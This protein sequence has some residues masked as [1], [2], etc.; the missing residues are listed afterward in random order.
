MNENILNTNEIWK[1]T[2]FWTNEI[3]KSGVHEKL[4]FFN[5]IITEKYPPHADSGYHLV[6][7]NISLDN[8]ECDIYHTDQDKNGEK[9]KDN[10]F[11]RIFIHIKE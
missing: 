6:L 3:I 11:S 5:D 1:G 10:N 7:P 9:I 2:K 8:K 4:A